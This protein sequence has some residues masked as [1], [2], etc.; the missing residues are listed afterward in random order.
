MHYVGVGISTSIVLENST[1]LLLSNPK[2]Y[3]VDTIVED[4]TQGQVL[5]AGGPG[6]INV[7]DWGFGRVTS[8]DGNTFTRCRPKYDDIG[9]SQIINARD[10]G[11][12]GDGKSDDTATCILNHLFAAAANMSA[13]KH[14]LAIAHTPRPP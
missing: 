9:Y 10:Y 12:R 11:A 13:T 5:L 1:A 8:A 3:Y 2:F 14:M 7:D 6:T 4:I